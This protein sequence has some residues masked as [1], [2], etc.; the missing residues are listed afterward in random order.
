MTDVLIED[1]P[2]DVI[3][4]IDANAKDCGLTREEYLR[5]R[6][7]LEKRRDR[8]VTVNDLKRMSEAMSD[9]LDP[10]FVKQAWR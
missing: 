3:D 8:R 9:A 4:A 1:V 10:E 7:T 6:L 5:S 2:D